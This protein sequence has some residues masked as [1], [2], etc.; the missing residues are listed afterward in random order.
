MPNVSVIHQNDEQKNM[1]ENSFVD[2]ELRELT[3][4][5]KEIAKKTDEEKEKVEKL[6]EE[7]EN[8]LKENSKKDEF[9]K[10]QDDYFIPLKDDPKF[11]N[12]VQ[13]LEIEK[14]LEELKE[15]A[16]ASI[17]LSLLKL[18]MMMS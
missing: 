8:K 15:Y 1:L 9:Q 10:K 12:K 4:Q 7:K 13:I 18:S 2:D 3:K 5:L 16:T 17:N 14:S 6:K 11:K